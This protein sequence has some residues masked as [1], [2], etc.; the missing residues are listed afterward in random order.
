MTD[1]NGRKYLRKARCHSGGGKQ[2]TPEAT[3]QTKEKGLQNSRNDIQQIQT[4]EEDPTIHNLTASLERMSALHKHR[5]GDYSAP[6]SQLNISYLAR[7]DMP[8]IHSTPT[9]NK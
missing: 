1:Q 8:S 3:R 9:Q 5:L 4:E 6:A 2:R 7:Y